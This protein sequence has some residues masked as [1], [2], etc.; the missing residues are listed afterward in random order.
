M[1][2]EEWLLQELDRWRNPAHAPEG[3]AAVRAA[4]DS[5]THQQLGSR[6]RRA[7]KAAPAHPVD[8]PLP[9]PC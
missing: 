2:D 4:V 7:F 5:A 9:P 3:H 1:S 8:W 6:L